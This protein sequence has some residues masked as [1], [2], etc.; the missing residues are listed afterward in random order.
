MSTRSGQRP[1]GWSATHTPE[2]VLRSDP[3]DF[4]GLYLRHRSSFVRHARGYLRNTHDVEEVVQDAFVRLFLALPELETEAQ[5]LVYC[6]RTITNLCIDRYRATARRPLFVELDSVADLAED[7][8]TDPVVQAEDAAIVRM[9]L[10]QLSPV[11]REA[12][13]K[14]EIEEKSVPEIAVEMGI[15]EPSVKHVLFRAR[16]ALRR[17][18][19]GTSVEP[20][21]GSGSLGWHIVRDS[22]RVLVLALAL[23]LAVG[24]TGGR[25]LRLVPVVGDALSD[26]PSLSEITAP[27]GDALGRLGQRGAA[28]PPHDH[29]APAEVGRSGG[30]PPVMEERP[31]GRPRIRTSGPVATQPSADLPVGARPPPGPVDSAAPGAPGLLP[32]PEQTIEVQVSAVPSLPATGVPSPTAT[33]T[34]SATPEAGTQ[35]SPVPSPTADADAAAATPGP[36]IPR[37]RR[38]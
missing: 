14:R 31:L 22:S 2:R 24:L 1:A 36:D 20:G 29:S 13:V 3:H 17:L 27:V 7:E 8:P 38:T 28:Q 11:H 34:P 5:A 16:R 18:L 23:A 12:L 35:P 19:V 26:L 10:S 4:A 21:G 32:G 9:A 15:P 37:K 30:R 6:R 25:D 33:A